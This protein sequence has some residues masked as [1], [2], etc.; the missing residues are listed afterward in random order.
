MSARKASLVPFVSQSSFDTNTEQHTGEVIYQ[1][2]PASFSDSDGDG[3][4]DIRGITS[5][6]D[7]IKSLG[8]D[9]IW[10][11]PFYDSPQGPEGDGGY[12]VSDYREIASRFG[13][14]EDFRQLLDE[15]H[16]RGLRIYT[17]FVIAHTAHDH[18][19]FEKSRR[20]EEP[21]TD[22]F[23]WHDGWINPE[24]QDAPPEGWQQR[25]HGE[26]WVRDEKDNK[27]HQHFPPNNWKS[28]FGGLAWTWDEERQQYYMHHF[29]KSQPALN[30]NIGKVQD[31]SLAEMK[32]WLDM[33]VDG[34]RIDA[35]PFA[36]YDSRLHNNPWL[37][38]KWPRTH[39]NW[40]DQHFEYSLCQ[41][42]TIEVVKRIRELMDSYPEKR[43]TLGEAVCGPHGGG[44]S[45]PVAA[46]YVDYKTGLDMCYTDTL[47][48]MHEYPSQD[49]LKRS[50]AYLLETFPASGGHCNSVDNHDTPRSA[51]RMT[52]NLP[53]TQ[54][55]AA[56]R[57]LMQL[58]VCLPGSFSM[59]QGQELGL[60]QARIPEDIPRDK[61]QDPTAATFGDGRD[62]CRTPMPWKTAEK[63]AGFT[64]SDTPYL[65]VPQSHYPLAVD[66]QESAPD[67][68]LRFTRQL[69]AW[70]KAQPALT[71]GRTVVI[72]NA[73]DVFAFVRQSKDQTMLCLF[74]MSGHACSFK[75]SDHI[76][77]EL[78]KKMNIGPHQTIKL[79]AHG[80]GFFGANPGHSQQTVLKKPPSPPGRGPG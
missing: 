11:S 20:R 7:Y 30:L 34:F 18:A 5:K 80:T 48:T 68:Q 45:I 29:L 8:V 31:A 54:K 4:G 35:L 70:R 27:W 22:Y 59:Y 26:V 76:D 15:A 21:Y 58:F 73:G 16:A 2:Y 41:P 1:V 24:G 69:L 37:D 60:P 77:G 13:S 74:N 67:S 44:G 25:P 32:F 47:T 39:E 52:A 33:G 78:L 49:R 28:V 55:N 19:W 3:L 51:S 12:A 43:T 64:P 79:A 66:H 75:P 36:N 46:S 40:G 23:V 17:D 63:H 6:L 14:M 72:D 9:A 56:L 38:G 62:G 50:L 53:D 61:L 42:Q 71:E 57:Q 65:P 10:I